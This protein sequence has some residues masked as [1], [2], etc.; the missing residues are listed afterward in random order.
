[1]SLVVNNN[2]M[3]NNVARNLNL[4]YGNLSTSTERLSS[5]LRINSAADDAA[6]LAIRE[7][8]RADITTLL[9]GARNAN[10][11]ISLIQTADG[12]LQTI[13]EQLIRMKE[14]AEQAATG[15]YNSTQRLMI[16]SEYQHLASEI[17][18]I[19]NA[20][21]FNGIKLLNGTLSGEY[22]GSELQSQGE[23]KIH[24]GTANTSAEDFY[25]VNIGDTKAAALGLGNELVIPSD[26]ET[27]PTNAGYEALRDA[28]AQKIYDA[29][30][31]ERYDAHYEDIYSRLVS[32]ADP[33]QPS[34]PLENAAAQAAEQATFL[35]GKE[36]SAD[37]EM[38]KATFDVIFD[39]TYA[40][41]Y[42]SDARTTAFHA[43]V[44]PTAQQIADHDAAAQD[45]LKAATEQMHNLTQKIAEDG[46][47]TSLDA[48]F[49]LSKIDFVTASGI[50]TMPEISAFPVETHSSS[51]A[52]MEQVGAESYK[53]V[54][55]RIYYGDPE[56]NGGTE[57]VMGMYEYAIADAKK[58]LGLSASE[59]LTEEQTVAIQAMVHSIA[60]NK[61]LEYA[62]SMQLG[63]QKKYDDSF[64]DLDPTSGAPLG[65]GYTEIYDDY[66]VNDSYPSDIAQIMAE[67]QASTE[68]ITPPARDSGWGQVHF[69]L[70]RGL[71]G[72]DPATGAPN[73]PT[74]DSLFISSTMDIPDSGTP[75]KQVT[76]L[77]NS[78]ISPLGN[79][80]PG[81]TAA[82]D[83][84]GAVEDNVLAYM[85]DTAAR[86]FN[87]SSQGFIETAA[88][89][90]DA[91][92]GY[93]P[94]GSTIST[95]EAAG[96]ALNAI[97]EAIISKDKIRAHLGA[98]QNRLEVTINN[99]NIQAENL[100]ASESRI[101]DVD[102]A[103]EMT[104]FVRNQ[105]LPQSA[106]AMLSQANSLP[107]MAQQVIGG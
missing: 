92:D 59:S 102:V 75:P 30:Y 41:H 27:N 68:G 98:M 64:Y 89:F 97:N 9:Q 36:A 42:M 56:A 74:R 66:T 60:H 13:D 87:G 86:G 29:G 76:A 18:R 54:Y 1:M 72:I 33:S 47:L 107:Q 91:F 83:I 5:G 73:Y 15:T 52:L 12:A 96:E 50:V 43:A 82:A 32:S 55:E 8:Q 90:A 35:A 40:S 22:D 19:S 85:T 39:H 38:A 101:S 69:D 4:H 20:T 103:T 44:T 11:A 48:M 106:V 16:E 67:T 77:A 10:D 37:A 93:S 79:L 26:M 99:L 2:L 81:Q 6:G 94:A 17:T 88:H 3:A 62:E 31:A 65:D 25:S 78:R 63:L 84:F 45:A 58:T 28:S 61:A 23:L 21:D 100:Q 70:G 71:Y 34:I 53:A 80:L 49:P 51:A 95:Q 24:F 104:E 57:D 105:I 46:N 14:L 7:L